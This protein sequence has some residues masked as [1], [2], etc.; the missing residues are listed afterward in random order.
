MS[1]RSCRGSARRLAHCP[2]LGSA[3]FC[4]IEFSG[5]RD[6][7]ASRAVPIAKECPISG[8]ASFRKISFSGSRGAAAL[9]L[10]LGR[11]VLIV[12]G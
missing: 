1:T 3:S 4:E 12:S 10:C 2:I 6:C 9:T 5:K 8:L 11:A 7:P